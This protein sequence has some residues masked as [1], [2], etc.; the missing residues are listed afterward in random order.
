VYRC[1]QRRGIFRLPDT[2]GD[3]PMRHKFKRHPIGCF[4][5]DI[6]ELRTKV[7]RLYLLVAIDQTTK[8]ALTQLVEK[9]GP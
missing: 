9:A 7:G 4:H 2:Q 8:F 1:L 6:A 3:K 5:I